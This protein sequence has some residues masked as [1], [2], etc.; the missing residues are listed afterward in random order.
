MPP[1]AFPAVLVDSQNVYSIPLWHPH[2]GALTKRVA[3]A[4]PRNVLT[5]T[6]PPK[7]SC[8]KHDLIALV[9]GMLIAVGRVYGHMVFKC[10]R[11][12]DHQTRIKAE[13]IGCT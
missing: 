10:E 1:I 7:A 12:P 8:L 6:T 4:L 13:R 5:Q 3:Q 11:S 9:W 2:W